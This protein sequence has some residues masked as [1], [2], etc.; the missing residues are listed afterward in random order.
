VPVAIRL[1][2]VHP[3]TGEVSYV[4]QAVDFDENLFRPLVDGYGEGEDAR[5]I[6]EE[7][8]DWWQRELTAIDEKL[9]RETR[10]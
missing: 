3:E 6:F 2:L 10:P 4:D 8:I 9:I 1:T 5:D 7:A